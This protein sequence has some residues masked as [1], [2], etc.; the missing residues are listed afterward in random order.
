MGRNARSVRRRQST[1]RGALP[2][3][4]SP[5]TCRAAPPQPARGAAF[6]S[7]GL[8]PTARPTTGLTPGVLTKARPAVTARPTTGLTP[9]VLT[10]ARP[11]V[12]ARPT[13]GLTP[14]VLTKA[15]PAVTAR[16]TT[17]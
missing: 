13:T 6:L 11:A 14:G 4:S 2:T 15:R 8:A 9:G 5:R 10:K 12:T 7:M 1:R 17:G 3:F 16:P